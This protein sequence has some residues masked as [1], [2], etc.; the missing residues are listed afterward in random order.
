MPK[1]KLRELVQLSTGFKTAVNLQTDLD[2]L[3]KAGGYLPTEVGHLI[4]FDLA[5][6]L[7]PSAARRA[8]LVM[9]TYGTGKSHLTLVLANLYA[10]R[11][12]DPQMAP[13]WQRL[14]NQWPGQTD[15][16]SEELERLGQPFLL[17]LLEGDEGDFN[18]ALLRGLKKAL[19]SDPRTAEMLPETVFTAA[20]R[21]LDELKGTYP[22]TYEAL[23]REFADRGL[24]SADAVRERLGEFDREAYRQFCEAHKRACAGAEF[25]PEQ[26]MRPSE[27]Y[28]S[29]SR[30][31]VGEGLYAG[32]A[33]FWDEFGR[34]M[35]RIAD[36]P[37]GGESRDIERFA[38]ACQVPQNNLH[39]YLICHRSLEEYAQISRLRRGLGDDRALAEDMR[40]AMGRFSPFVM[41]S[42]DAEVFQ[43]ID[44]VLIQD[45]AGG[46]WGALTEARRDELNL[47]T[48]KAVDLRLFPDFASEQ[49]HRVVTLG[50][51]PVH[52]L[53]AFCLP[54]LS[55][56]V[57]QNE[58]TLFTYLSDSGHR[59]LGEFV[60]Q[61]AV[62]A[63]DEP[64]PLATVPYLWDYFEEQVSR[65]ERTR[66][67]HQL[68]EAAAARVPTSSRY[69]KDI[70]KV[71]AVFEAIQSDRGKPTAD[72]L[73][74][75]L[76]L[77][78]SRA[79]DLEGELEALATGEDRVLVRSV[80]DGSYRFARSTGPESLD[81]KVRA[82]VG[83]RANHVDPIAHLNSVWGDLGLAKAVPATG[84]QT[85]RFVPRK[86]MV[87]AVAPAGLRN[88]SAWTRDL[89]EGRFVD[90][91]LLMV[92]AEDSAQLGQARKLVKQVQH[93][94]I[95]VAVPREPLTRCLGHLRRHEALL[96]LERTESNLYG[97]GA[98]LREEWEQSLSEYVEL[99]AKIFRPLL[100]GEQGRLDA[101]AWFWRGEEQ[102]GVTSVSR[103]TALATEVME[104]VFTCTP[105][106]RHDVLA[107]EGQ[108]D[109]FRKH[110]IPVIDLL[111]NEDGPGLLARNNVK[112]QKH[113]IDALLR[114]N[115]VLKSQNGRYVVSAPNR[116]RSSAM[117]AVWDEIS[118]Y[119]EQ[120]R[121]GAQDLLRLVTALRR[122]PYGLPTRCMPVLLAAVARDRVMLGNIVLEHRRTQTITDRITRLSG[123]AVE[124]AFA[125]PEHYRVA[126]LDISGQQ[127]SLIEGLS[128]GLGIEL[129]ASGETAE[130]IEAAAEGTRRWWM[131][132]PRHGHL[133][134]RLSDESAYLRR[135]VF[136]PLSHPEGDAHRI[137]LEVLPSILKPA[138]EDSEISA[139]AVAEVFARVKG[140]FESVVARLSESVGQVVVDVFA[141]SDSQGASAEEAISR[142]FAGLPKDTR[143]YKFAGDAGKLTTAAASV[144]EGSVQ[145]LAEAVMG[146]PLSQ[147]ADELVTQF[148][149]R[150]ESAKEHVETFVLPLPPDGK[151]PPPAPPKHAR[152]VLVT[153]EGTTEKVFLLTDDLSENGRHLSSVLKSAVTGM[154]STLPDGECL[155]ILVRLLKEALN[156][157]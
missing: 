131:S 79:G 4:I 28:Q 97:P 114:Q 98:E 77:P 154:G 127:R 1:T 59:T 33:V 50:S 15:R 24:L 5:E 46:A 7:H 148:R 75:A 38:E 136:V 101:V 25:H 155:T 152:V 140:E 76:H 31:L 130:M 42:S 126:Y 82:L 69:G 56:M 121:D 30:K 32:I 16:L 135:D 95:V 115:D 57:A 129:P 116:D 86:L 68:Y 74:Y 110:R 112:P 85:D 55:E 23:N 49:V 3:T 143:T 89:G 96:F 100:E 12:S 72:I 84:Y 105:P 11:H 144:G 92:V 17:V 128:R 157:Y 51:F 54:R 99:L 64:L 9:G 123:E 88:L 139:E 103:L 22:E 80:A 90:G 21:R 67:V 111:F 43:L 47:L 94:Q 70:L 102:Q 120:C 34:Y 52:P 41:R 19:R 13:L 119:L 29:V 40:K 141:G 156:G 124:A 58:R 142:W 63:K 45:D 125:S 153:D 73:K 145:Q 20:A 65:D 48:E 71:I 62:P 133:T 132:L 104:E 14:R 60:S 35:E 151:W 18:S 107:D 66:R 137:L 53:A 78:V 118:A 83:E 134:H 6:N 37:S 93:A 10:K 2:N 149:G 26:M 113:V 81:D 117:A 61:R 147:W 146:L 27:I 36:D 39:L 91:Y 87:E 122:P 150:L 106:I 138:D 109:T 44:Q 108:R 8:R